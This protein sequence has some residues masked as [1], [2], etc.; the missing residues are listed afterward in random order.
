ME[1]YRKIS[2]E[3][4]FLGHSSANLE[5]LTA[6]FYFPS[7]NTQFCVNEII[8]SDK[9]GLRESFILFIIFFIFLT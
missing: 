3:K 7:L 4:S 1:I 9:K 8:F 6:H 5:I 2:V